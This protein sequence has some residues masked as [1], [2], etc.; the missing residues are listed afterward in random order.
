MNINQRIADL[1]SRSSSYEALM[2][3]MTADMRVFRH[4]IVSEI[5][6]N[7]EFSDNLLWEMRDALMAANQASQVLA[8]TYKIV[9]RKAQER[10][11]EILEREIMADMAEDLQDRSI[12]RV[13]SYR[14]LSSAT[15]TQLLQSATAGPMTEKR[16][17]RHSMYMVN[18]YFPGCLNKNDDDPV[19]S[20][21]EA[22][23]IAVGIANEYRDNGWC[24]TGNCRDGYEIKYDKYSIVGM[25]LYVSEID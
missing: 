22:R 11:G 7:T 4:I 12:H 17:R 14:V 19:S 5:V 21:K 25:L 10:I 23:A 18:L 13:R 8:C 20:L 1:A 16:D 3:A 2:H 15:P 9:E 24:V 6:A